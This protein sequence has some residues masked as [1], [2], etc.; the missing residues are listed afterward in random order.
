MGNGIIQWGQ[1]SEGFIL[2]TFVL[3][4]ISY[5]GRFEVGGISVYEILN[6][7]SRMLIHSLLVTCYSVD[8]L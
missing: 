3:G 6:K 4:S 1:H 8:F 5:V 7:R 2:A